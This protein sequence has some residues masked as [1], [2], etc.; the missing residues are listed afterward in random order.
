MLDLER[1]IIENIC[2][3]HIKIRKI[4]VTKN[5]RNNMK[6]NFVFYSLLFLLGSCL[7]LT[8]L[9]SAMAA[10]NY[11]LYIA[12]GIDKVNQSKFD[13]AIGL[14]QKALDA[15]PD[16]PEAIYYT[17]VANSR[18]GNLDTAEEMFKRVIADKEYTANAHLELGRVY[19]MKGR[20]DM[21]KQYLE[22]FISFTSNKE[23]A[24]Y[25]DN[26]IQQCRSAERRDREDEPY[27]LNISLGAQYDSNVVLEP[28]NPL[29]SKDK[30]DGRIFGLVNAG[31]DIVKNDTFK[32][33]TDY[34]FY[35][36]FHFDLNNSPNDFDVQYH[37]LTPSLEL[38][39]FEMVVPSVGY[40]LE[41]VRFGNDWYGRIQT[42]F[43]KVKVREGVHYSTEG[44]Y[45][46]R[47]I[48]YQ[49]TVLF[50]SNSLR[51]GWKHT[52]G[53]KQNF[54]RGKIE[55]DI[56]Y[57]YDDKHASTSYW[58][59]RGDR[60]GTEVLYQIKEP[61]AVRGAVDYNRRKYRGVFPG[62]GV[63][64]YDKAMMY[65]LDLH[66]Q[67]AENFALTLSETYIDNRSNNTTFDYDRNIIG[68]MVTWGAI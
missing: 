36:S 1:V 52:V 3:L 31:A 40:T 56:H 39:V 54:Y 14:L 9:T 59:Y 61:L 57:Y 50:A 18:L 2:N 21:S 5:E 15:S 4:F 23:A 32:F 63:I 7:L 35:Q 16:N 53:V 44:I 22:K 12:Q 26:L 10:N 46:Y 58:S 65:R 17:G 41:H 11:E 6:R 25:A 38:T 34:T 43:G 24:A 64:R 48:D 42:Y 67:L 20:C 51:S 66:Y 49:N 47:D 68:A 30:S 45:E 29:I 60:V 13:E 55:G 27:K 37:G 28:D 33:R 19:Y 62:L 8:S